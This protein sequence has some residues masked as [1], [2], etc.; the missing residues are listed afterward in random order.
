MIYD[1]EKIIAILSWI[2]TK[3]CD[4]MEISK[5]K[6]RTKTTVEIYI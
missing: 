4:W 5:K 2:N 6:N 1:Y 3:N